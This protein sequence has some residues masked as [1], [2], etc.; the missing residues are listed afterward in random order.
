MFHYKDDDQHCFSEHD[1]RDRGFTG[2]VDLDV[3]LTR[4]PDT[5]DYHNAAPTPMPCIGQ[6][7]HL[8][9]E[10][11][12]AEECSK[13]GYTFLGLGRAKVVS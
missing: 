10:F 4:M 9:Q 3:K 11:T 2:N 8:Y 7:G 6:D 1:P 5:I 13:A 12:T